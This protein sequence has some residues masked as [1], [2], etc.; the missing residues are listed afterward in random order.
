MRKILF[1][2]LSVQCAKFRTTIAFFNSKLLPNFRRF[3]VFRFGKYKK[4]HRIAEIAKLSPKFHQAKKLAILPPSGG[5]FAAGSDPG[6]PALV[7]RPRLFN[8]QIVRFI[9]G[10]D[11]IFYLKK[12]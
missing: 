1:S 2:F 3:A 12:I 8:A 6:S 11:I 10:K 9:F 7:P 5:G 4:Y